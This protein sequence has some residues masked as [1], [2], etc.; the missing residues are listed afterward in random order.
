MHI[1]RTTILPMN[2]SCSIKDMDD[3]QLVELAKNGESRAYDELVKRHS[4]KLH[5]VLY[6]MTDSYDDAYDIAQEAFAKAYR[7]LR[8]FNGQ[9][10]FYTW[11]HSIALNHARNFL[12]KRNKRAMYSLDDDEYG[13]HEEKDM[14][15]ADDSNGSDPEKVLQMTELK[16]KIRE[17]LLKLSDKH[18]EIVVLHD[19]R[20]LSHSEISVMLGISE[21][22][23]RSRLH[24]AHKQLQ[25]ILSEYLE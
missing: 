24:Y 16:D 13:S 5:S 9:S 18:R 11:L 19:V 21:G 20:G 3:V 25:G 4:R 12:K 8:Y 10:A 17:A 15:M 7:S 22:T 23:M 2:S 1:L 6:Q 14:S